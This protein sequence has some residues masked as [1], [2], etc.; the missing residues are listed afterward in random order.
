MMSPELE[1]V[2]DGGARRRAW[3]LAAL[4]LFGALLLALAWQEL[5]WQTHEPFRLRGVS[6]AVGAP[7]GETLSVGYQLRNESRLPL[8]IES[9]E[10]PSER[11]RRITE[12]VRLDVLEVAALPSGELAIAAR[13][14]PLA[15]GLRTDD[16]EGRQVAPGEDLALVVSYVG[17]GPGRFYVGPFLVGYRFGPFRGEQRVPLSR[18]YGFEITEPED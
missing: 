6:H 9:I 17:D 18:A 7:V 15:R 10:L 4:L 8:R 2:E 14:R 5:R 11:R 1:P 3:A 16:V 12:T 13:G